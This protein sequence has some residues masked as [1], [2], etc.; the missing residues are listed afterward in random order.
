MADYT[1]YA[2]LDPEWLEFSKTYKPPPIPEDL[3]LAKTAINEARSSLFKEVLGPIEVLST[4]DL[5]IPTRDGNSIPVRLYFPEPRARISALD[6]LPLY[7]YLHGGGWLFGSLDSED[8]HCRLITVSVGCIVL[9]VEYR[10]T[11]ESKFP[12]QYHD[13]FD[14][15][16]WI[17]SPD[18]LEE[19]SISANN[20]V[21]G[22]V[23]AGG[24]LS[25]ASAVREIERGTHRIKGIS[26]SLPSPVHWTRF[27]RHL[28]KDGYSSFEQN[29]N[30]PLLPMARLE[31]LH[32]LLK[33]D[34]DSP[35]VSPFLLPDSMLQQFP[36][37][38]FHVC[39]ADP[40][41]D[42]GLLFEEKLK[43]LGVETRMRVFQGWPHAFWNL[44][45]I[46]FSATFR[47]RMIGD[48]EWLFGVKNV[49]ASAKLGSKR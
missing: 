47:Q 24:T 15:V 36:P 26:A 27:P 7:V 44:P 20:V 45:Q 8:M 34:P 42:G 32:S 16:D 31:Y 39:G 13:V 41:R 12:T 3:A 21:V 23:S 43:C 49:A 4:R 48:A 10:H 28:V 2:E 38:A 30:V 19:Y 37:I 18:R 22:G 29:A 17:L 6:E 5:T 1:H 25:I 9:N 46:K 11:P 14:A 33:A 40:L 35:Y